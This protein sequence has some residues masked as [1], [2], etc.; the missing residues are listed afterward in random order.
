MRILGASVLSERG[1]MNRRTQKHLAAFQALISAASWRAVKDLESQFGHVVTLHP[2]DRIT[3]NFP[4]ENLRVEMRVNFAL[5]LVL[6]VNESTARQHR[7]KKM[8][9]LVRPIRNDS[10]YQAALVQID[11]LFNAAAGTPEADRAE[12][13]AVLVADYERRWHASNQADPV[14]V[15]TLSMK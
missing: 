3:F 12:V 11:A 9:E 1:R 5:G 8:N 2:P 4:D 13:L 14:D 7:E 6:V 15:L 10:D